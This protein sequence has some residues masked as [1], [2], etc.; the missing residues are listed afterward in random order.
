MAVGL[1]YGT[2]IVLYFYLPDFPPKAPNMNYFKLV[3]YAFILDERVVAK[4]VRTD[5]LWMG[6]NCGAVCIV[7]EYLGIC[8]SFSDFGAVLLD[9]VLILQ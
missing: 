4:G 3:R 6:D 1:Q 9:R 5:G 7:V 8:R 2:C